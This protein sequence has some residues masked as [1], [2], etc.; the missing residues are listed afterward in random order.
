[1]GCAEKWKT[2]ILLTE[3]K[4]SLTEKKYS[5]PSRI[6]NFFLIKARSHTTPTTQILSNL[7]SFVGEY[8]S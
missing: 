6:D 4:M 7:N 1:M 3:K 8:I 5:A 2:S